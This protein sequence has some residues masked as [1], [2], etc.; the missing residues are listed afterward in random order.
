MAG[1]SSE[2]IMTDVKTGAMRETAVSIENS[3][4]AIS[5]AEEGLGRCLARLQAVWEG[6]AATAYATR[7]EELLDDMST[8]GDVY[9]RL[10]ADIIRNAEEYE[11]ADEAASQIAQEILTP[12][13]AE[14][15][16]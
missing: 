3:L 12:V 14:V 8:V 16:Q 11:S 9:V 7:Y 5:A 15:C 6:A 2:P 4:K 13:W 1:F 10:A